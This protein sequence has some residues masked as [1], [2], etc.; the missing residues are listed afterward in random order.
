MWKLSEYSDDDLASLTEQ[1]RLERLRRAGKARPCDQCGS[2]FVGRSDARFC[3]SSCRVASHREAYRAARLVPQAG[4]IP[5]ELRLR[6]RWVRHIAKRPVTASGSPASSTNSSTWTTY[7]VASRS[8]VG[9]G[10]GFVLAA[11]DG[12]GCY[13]LDHCVTDGVISDAALAYLGG[14]DPFYVEFSPSGDGLHAWVF[15]DT[16]RGWRKSIDGL[17][18]EFYTMGR[19]MT[20]TGRKV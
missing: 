19:Y 3:S 10:L 11:G 9:D 6:P 14:I 15:A 7:E 8:V 5:D 17:S 20:V 16:Q 1:I 2:D 12:I 13:D 18:V 4:V